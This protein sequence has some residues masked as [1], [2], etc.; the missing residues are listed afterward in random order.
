MTNSIHPHQPVLISKEEIS[1]LHFP[2]HEVLSCKDAILLRHTNL[3]NAL[4]LGNI[5]NHK[6][7]IIFQDNQGLKQVETTIWG[8]TDKRVILKQGVLIPISCIHEV[9]L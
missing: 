9:R 7:K 6:I 2:N 3:E 5:E 4:K 1:G 8:V